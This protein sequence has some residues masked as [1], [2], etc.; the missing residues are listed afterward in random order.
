MVESNAKSNMSKKT[1]FS[2]LRFTI[3]KFFEILPTSINPAIFSIR[4]IVVF[5]LKFMLTPL[6]FIVLW[7]KHYTTKKG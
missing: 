6:M 3:I 5:N 1:S 2:R 4:S 7:L